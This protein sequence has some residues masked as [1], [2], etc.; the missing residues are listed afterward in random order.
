MGPMQGATMAST[1]VWGHPRLDPPNHGVRER[2]TARPHGTGR[3]GRDRN[4][5]DKLLDTHHAHHRSPRGDC[6]RRGFIRI[7][8]AAGKVVDHANRSETVHCAVVYRALVADSVLHLSLSGQ[9]Q[10]DG[11][12]FTST[13]LTDEPRC[14]PPHAVGHYAILCNMPP[15][16][17]TAGRA[18]MTMLLVERG[19]HVIARVDRAV[20]VG[21]ADSPE[22][23]GGQFGSW[24][25]GVKPLLK[26]S[27]HRVNPDDQ[28]GFGGLSTHG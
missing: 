21:M 5:D 22:Q 19:R 6:A 3:G 14:A 24:G 18:S 23:R 10:E 4:S 12:V 9:N 16:C 8:N 26:W 25:G 11:T 7:L 17:C 28:I 2:R 1:R 27:R 13:N 15:N 20:S